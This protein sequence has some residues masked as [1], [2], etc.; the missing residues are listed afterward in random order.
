ML[1]R[2]IAALARRVGGTH[3]D[4]LA[5]LWEAR[6]ALDQA[7]AAAVDQLRAR[8]HSWAELGAAVGITAQGM[9]QWRG[10]ASRQSAL[11]NPLMMPERRSG[12]PPW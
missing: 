5:V 6:D 2:M 1:T 7:A 12:E 4:E 3:A 9:C 10:R 8:G 11:N